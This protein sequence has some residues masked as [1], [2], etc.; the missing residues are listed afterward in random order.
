LVFIGISMG[1]SLELC[2]SQ[3]IRLSLQ[4]KHALQLALSL[5]QKLLA[6][7][8]IEAKKGLEGMLTADKMLKERK[9]VGVLVGSL[10][11]YIWN[12]NRT[13]A[14]LA[15]KKDVD[16]LVLSPSFKLYKEFEGGI[17]WWM[18]HES[19]MEI[20]YYGSSTLKNQQWWE[21][22][23]SFPL[24]FEVNMKDGDELN[25][26]LYIP[27]QRF[28]KDMRLKEARSNID[29]ATVQ[30][31]D[32]DAFDCALDTKIESRYKMGKFLPKFMQE[33]FEGHI[34]AEPYEKDWR[35]KEAFEVNEFSIEIV[36]QINKTIGRMG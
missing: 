5:Q 18:P 35:R 24:Q 14:E 2:Q 10:S 30:I 3:D 6:P 16:V 22:A 20:Q 26:G 7:E 28:V 32:E 31:E 33:R 15:K 4:Q 27:S 17:D 29:Y 8:P 12:R 19:K 34:L 11:S 23:A 21:N 36:R 25:P 9:G 1:L 13:E